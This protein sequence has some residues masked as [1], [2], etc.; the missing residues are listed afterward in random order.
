MLT[1]AD[2]K[3]RIDALQQE[4]GIKTGS[5]LARWFDIEPQAVYQWR[6]GYLPKLRAYQLIETHPEFA[7]LVEREESAA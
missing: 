4:L 3:I 5:E 6:D 1:I 2:M 7:H